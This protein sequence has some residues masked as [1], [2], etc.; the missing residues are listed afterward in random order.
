M[1]RCLVIAASGGKQSAS[2]GL[3]P[4]RN[5]GVR[6]GGAVELI[7]I[8]DRRKICASACEV[9]AG[10]QAPVFEAMRNRMIDKR[11]GTFPSRASRW[12]CE[13]FQ[14]ADAR[15][16]RFSHAN[17]GAK[18]AFMSSKSKQT[19]DTEV[20]PV[21]KQRTFTGEEKLRILAAYEG[22]ATSLERAAV[23]RRER[24]PPSEPRPMSI[25]QELLAAGVP[26]LFEL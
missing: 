26:S 11:R 4:R 21:V 5:G 24:I 22:A 1:S 3:A 15:G 19:G 7:A 12:C 14:R 13:T 2:S 6:T 9:G 16:T 20:R 23:L 17:G 8:E 10:A 25:E 18:V